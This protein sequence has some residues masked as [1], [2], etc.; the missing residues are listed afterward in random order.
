MKN[1]EFR[2]G[3]LPIPDHLAA[4][5]A[6]LETHLMTYDEAIAAMNRRF[7]EDRLKKVQADLVRD[8]LH[9]FGA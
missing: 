3:Y 8:H 5:M 9:K 7:M 2:G 6:G 1:V 4:L